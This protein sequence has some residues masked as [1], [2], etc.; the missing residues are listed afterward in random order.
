[1]IINQTLAFNLVRKAK[2]INYPVTTKLLFCGLEITELKK[3]VA[4]MAALG[5][6]TYTLSGPHRCKIHLTDK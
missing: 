2:K 5:F 4:T 1:M 6:C 3:I